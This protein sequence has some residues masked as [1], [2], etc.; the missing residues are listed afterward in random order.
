MHTGAGFA[1]TALY[2]NLKA[3]DVPSYEA[4]LW[5]QYDSPDYVRNLFNI[6][7][8]A[9]SGD[10]D[11]QKKAGIIL[12]EAYAAHGK[13]LEHLIAP[14]TGHKYHPDYL[15]Q[16]M[17]FVDK[18]I[19]EGRN[20]LPDHVYLQTKTLRYAKMYW[21][22]VLGL[23]QHWLDSR[24]DADV[25]GKSIT[26][27]SINIAR[28][29]LSHPVIKNGATITLDGQEIKLSGVDKTGAVFERSGA[30][31]TQAKTLY[32]DGLSKRPGLQ[33]PIDDAFVRPFL[34]V[35]PSKTCADAAVDRWVKAESAHFIE[36]WAA[37]MRGN[38]LVK[39]DSEVTAEDIAHY[40][41]ILWGDAKANSLL[42]KVLPQLP[43]RWSEQ[44]IQIG[45]QTFPS[46]GH[47]PTCIYPN[48]LNPTTY[49]VLNSGLT[50]RENHDRTNSLQN[51]K[52]PDWAVIDLKTPPSDLLPGTIV[53]ADFFGE[54]WEVK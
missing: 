28:L 7:V 8:I 13:S 27:T 15:K 45:K 53:A 46:A 35:L 33:G 19:A 29:Q 40:N 16:V 21:V 1:E 4:I 3:S 41:L 48:P 37:L 18:A 39:Q 25:V 54:Q 14:K 49:L 32:P 47:V 51:P 42:A 10:E 2:Q 43:I 12:G 36:R 50:F 30:K 26:L 11:T 38:A 9:Y 20:P 34:L 22:E 44:A 24:V 17:T 52:L 6:P 23:Q 31:W 5:G